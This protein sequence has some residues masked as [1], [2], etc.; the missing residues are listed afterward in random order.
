M[1]KHYSRSAIVFFAF[2]VWCMY[3]TKAQPSGKRLLKPDFLA[4]FQHTPCFQPRVEYKLSSKTSIQGTA[5]FC[6][7]TFYTVYQSPETPDYD[8][9]NLKGF[10][11]R[12][13]YRYYLQDSGSTM[14]GIYI[15]PEIGYKYVNY[16]QGRFFHIF[17][18]GNIN[19]Q[20]LLEYSVNKTTYLY[21]IKIG[22]QQKLTKRI[23]YDVFGGIGRRI[24]TLKNNMKIPDDALYT[25]EVFSGGELYWGYKGTKTRFS[26]AG[27]V[28]LGFMF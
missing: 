12:L 4:L 19:Y 17:T 24:I 22:Y 26:V 16:Q 18:A 3:F 27:S 23:Y 28:L 5:G 11:S 15:A 7:G 2:W 21:H 10:S 1:D 25:E 20:K 9:A 13:E 14:Q 6:Y 8:A